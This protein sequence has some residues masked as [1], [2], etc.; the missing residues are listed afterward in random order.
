MLLPQTNIDVVARKLQET[1][2][3]TDLIVVNPWYLGISFSRY[4]HGETPWLTL[5]IINDH[6]FHRYDLLKVKMLQSDPLADLRDA[7][8]QALQSGN[9]VWVVGGA[10]PPENGLPLSIQPAPDPEFGWN[11][12]AYLNVWSMQLG[13]FLRAHVRDGSVVLPRDPLVNINENVPLLI[14]SGWQD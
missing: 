9:R 8:T 6:R 2:R 1:T 5:P 12:Q 11:G 3:S 4:Y 7:I 14:G 10:R 13:E